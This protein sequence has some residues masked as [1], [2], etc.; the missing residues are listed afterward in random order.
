MHAPPGGATCHFRGATKRDRMNYKN[1]LMIH[2]KFLSC[3]KISLGRTVK[4]EVYFQVTFKA[5]K[6]SLRLVSTSFSSKNFVHAPSDVIIPLYV[7]EH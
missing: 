4:F 3:H 6:A 5:C 2:N 1:A 7:C